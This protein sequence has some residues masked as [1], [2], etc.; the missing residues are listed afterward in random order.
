LYFFFFF[1]FFFFCFF[2]CFF[3]L[4]SPLA[5][6]TSIRCAASVSLRDDGLGGG[7]SILI[8]W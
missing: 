5:F 6:H 1:L 8:S 2:F 3:P 4:S 7:P